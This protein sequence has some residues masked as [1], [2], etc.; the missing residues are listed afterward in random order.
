MNL[1]NQ[2]LNSNYARFEKHLP[3]FRNRCLLKQYTAFGV[4]LRKNNIKRIEPTVF[5]IFIYF[6]LNSFSIYLSWAF[7]FIFGRI[8]RCLIT[9]DMWW[10]KRW[11]LHFLNCIFFLVDFEIRYPTTCWRHLR[12]MLLTNWYTS[13]FNEIQ[14]M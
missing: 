4:T 6:S 7:Y 13:N 11:R 8:I 14:N 10:I 5:R 1:W 12:F 2:K 3:P 9:S